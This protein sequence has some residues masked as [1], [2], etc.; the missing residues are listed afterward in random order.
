[1]DAGQG[2]EEEADM[3]GVASMKFQSQAD[4]NSNTNLSTVAVGSWR[5]YNSECKWRYKEPQ[6]D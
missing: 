6:Q 4:L 5:T 1:M 2:E 3:K